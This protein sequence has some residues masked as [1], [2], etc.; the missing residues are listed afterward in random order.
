MRIEING[1][2][3]ITCQKYTQYYQKSITPT[4]YGDMIPI[5]CGFC[6]HKGKSV[7]PGD[8]CSYYHERS[9]VGAVVPVKLT[10]TSD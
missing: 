10:G 5:D 2:R 1:S 4:N 6:G 8:R 3:C 9:N 7:R